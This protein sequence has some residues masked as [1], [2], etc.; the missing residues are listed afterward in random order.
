M[1]DGQEYVLVYADDRR[2]GRDERREWRDPARDLP[3]LRLRIP[4]NEYILEARAVVEPEVYYD[5]LNQPPVERVQRL[6]SLDEVRYS[7]RVRDS[8]R[9]VDL[10]TVTFDFGSAAVPEAEIP[11]L[12]GVADAMHRLLER[13]PAE[14][15][16]IEG[17]TDAVGSDL[18]NL[19]LS[20]R[21]AEGVAAALTNVFDIPPENLV[22]QGYGK[23]YLKIDTQAPERAN[24]RV[25]IRRITPLIA[26][27]A[28]R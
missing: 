16:L 22:T 13:N 19:V 9:R 8:V 14:T 7:A 26:P 24:R 17:H 20:D 25:A 4:R 21:R 5:F 10:D 23:R 2:G 1:P 3:P 18:A 28:S 12:A 11:R 6:Y 15:F 27:V